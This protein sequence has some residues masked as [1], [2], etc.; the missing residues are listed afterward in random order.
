M[1][2]KRGPVNLELIDRKIGKIG[3]QQIAGAEIGL[4]VLPIEWEPTLEPALGDLMTA[5][6]WRQSQSS[7]PG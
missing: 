2:H 7:Q 5:L 3:H 1:R 6:E 4:K